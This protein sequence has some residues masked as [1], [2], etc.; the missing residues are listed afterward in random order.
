MKFNEYHKKKAARKG[1]IYKTYERMNAMSKSL[2]FAYNNSIGG[3]IMPITYTVV[4]R[5]C[6]DAEG[7]W[8]ECPMENG[9][10]VTQAA[11][12]HEI[13]KNMLEAVELYLEDYPEITNYYLA[14]EVC[15]AENTDC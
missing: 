7:Y 4:I 1:G 10:C 13:Q 12:L 15:D 8:A 6:V 3:D 14:F 5:P 11:T 9:G 2:A